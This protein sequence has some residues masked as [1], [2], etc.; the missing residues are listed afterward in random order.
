MT[1]KTKVRTQ[2]ERG[3]RAPSRE[4][5]PAWTDTPW[6]APAILVLTTGIVAAF[7]LWQEHRVAGSWGYSLDDSWI[8]ATMARNLARGQG[9]SFNP[10]HPVAGATGPLYTFVLAAFYWLFHEV[11][12][13]AKSFSLLCQMG[14]AF[15]T[16]ETA[17]TLLPGRRGIALLAGVL[18]GTAPALVW[19]SLSGM[20]ISL[21]LLVVCVGLL[22]YVRGR[23]RT[24]VL[25]WSIGVWVRPDGL[26]LVALAI[27]FGAP[28]SIWKRALVAAPVLAGFFAF[29][30]AIGGHW[31]PQTVGAKAHF[32]FEPIT[33]TW[34]LF[35]EWTALWGIPYRITD[36]LEEPVLLLAIAAIGAVASIRKKPLLALYWIGLP[37]VLSLFRE[38][39]A[40]HKRYI[41]YVIP[42]GILLGAM[43]LA[44]I[45]D[46]F[47]ARAGAR[48]AAL[49]GLAC[50]VWQLAYA[51]AEAEMHGWNVQ[52]INGMQRALG[53]FAAK[54]T[55]PG[56]P[57]ATNDIGAIAYFSGRPVVDLMGLITPQEPFPQMLA[58]YKPELLIIF[59]DWFHQYALW[60]PDTQGFVFLDPNRTHKYM[61]VG[62]IELHH[63]T[64]SAKDQMLAFRRLPIDAPAPERLLMEVH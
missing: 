47:G 50:L 58:R 59:V 19:A 37:L 15:A 24:A 16:Y 49:A 5:R 26:F 28:R 22:A 13:T 11:V 42:F 51:R 63:N 48:I 7:Y 30:H 61:I 2:A 25:L 14:A 36:D 10:G 64:I 17:R 27:A 35:R 21:Y 39:S 45:A 6:L 54:I 38:N 33:R 29:N 12:W 18:L 8:Y 23:A 52:N 9:F 3:S 41:L 31:M 1:S 55:R 44:V 53:E 40:S 32:G 62:A 60:D 43:G 46:R 4:R 56:D 20:E 34:K 57:I